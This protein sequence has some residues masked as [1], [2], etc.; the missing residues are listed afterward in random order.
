M[1]RMCSNLSKLIRPYT[2]EVVKNSVSSL[3]WFPK[4][5]SLPNETNQR[6][7][8][9]L[10]KDYSKFLFFPT[11]FLS[12]SSGIHPIMSTRPNIS[13]FLFVFCICACDCRRPFYIIGHMVNSIEQITRY[14]DLGANVI[15]SD[16]QFH[17][18]GSVKE[19]YHGFPC[20]CFRTCSRSAN[21]KD[22][23]QYVRQIT[24]PSTGNYADKMVMQ[25]FDLKVSRSENKLY[26]GQDL[27]RHVLDYL[28]SQDGSRKQEASKP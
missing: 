17:P 25:F 2:Y 18:N 15:E 4:D 20:D 28:W 24:D 5:W 13:F 7:I 8:E 3:K 16:I 26:S 23:L 19:A 12:S 10:T 27:A 21:L 14:L 1:T 6:W 22:F 9:N 11:T